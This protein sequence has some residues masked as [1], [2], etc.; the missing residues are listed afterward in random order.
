MSVITIDL[1]IPDEFAVY[2]A[3]K[4]LEL[5]RAEDIKLEASF[6][7]GLHVMA[8]VDRSFVG[9]VI[10]HIDK[11]VDYSIKGEIEHALR[12]CKDL[13]IRD[14]ISVARVLAGDDIDRVL[15][16]ESKIALPEQ[17][18]FDEYYLYIPPTYYD[19]IGE[20]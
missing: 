8:Y 7:K 1:D 19:N 14:P 10:R 4:V 9:E 3:M 13:K 6:S 16:D 17:V 18:L 20:D 15:A 2:R 12:I 11:L 5:L